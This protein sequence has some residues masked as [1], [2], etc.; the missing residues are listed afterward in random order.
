MRTLSAEILKLFTTRVWFWLT[1]TVVVLMGGIALIAGLNAEDGNNDPVMDP[2]MGMSFALAPIAY[3]VACVVG[4]TGLTGEFRHQTATS[5]FLAQPRRPIVVAAKLLVYLFYGAILGVL[6]FATLVLVARPLFGDQ[7]WDTSLSAGP[8]EFSRV[9]IGVVAAI[10]FFAP[11]GVGFGALV[12]NQ[13]AAI[14]VATIY[15]L[16]ADKILLAF[17][18]GKDLYPYTPG[19]AALSMMFPLDYL[20]DEIDSSVDW[21]AGTGGTVTLAIW[22]LGLAIVGS[23][24]AV[25]RDIT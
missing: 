3:V 9:A 13:P 6:A 19:G 8:Y 22:S 17:D 20:N 25:S 7:D 4:V 15:L 1:V 21:L 12:R 11:F 18:W 5:T 23:L 2:I 16:G 24:V 10:A 14:T